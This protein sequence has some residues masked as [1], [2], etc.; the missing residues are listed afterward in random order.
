[1]NFG[2]VIKIEGREYVF[3]LST[4]DILSLAWIPDKDL[5][6]EFIKRSKQVFT[7]GSNNKKRQFIQ[8]CFIELATKE[9]KER[10]AHYGN[11][12]RNFTPEDLIDVIGELCKEDKLMLKK[13]I[14]GDLAV[15][16]SLIKAVK[17][18]SI[19]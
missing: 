18:I 14:T 15:S 4:P 6:Q 13:A 2:D 1:M 19:E 12:D 17:D 5:S 11:P 9:F 7:T 3:L 8:W 16:K 10:I